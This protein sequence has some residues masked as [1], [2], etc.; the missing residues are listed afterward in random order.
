MITA[1]LARERAIKAIKKETLYKIEDAIDKAVEKGCLETNI[2]LTQDECC[3]I[4][5]DELRHTYNYKATM[6]YCDTIAEDGLFKI[7]LK[8]EW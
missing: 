7:N 8:L 5:V 2:S 6:T 4:L 1:G 3:D